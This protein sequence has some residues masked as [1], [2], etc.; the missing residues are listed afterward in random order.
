MKTL[1]RGRTVL[2]LD[3]ASY[4]RALGLTRQEPQRRF[5]DRR[6]AELRD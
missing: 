3:H 6:L 1:L 2:T 4:E 5:L